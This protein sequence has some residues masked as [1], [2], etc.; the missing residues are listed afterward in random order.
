MQITSELIERLLY[1]EES[2]TLDFKQGQYPFDNASDEQKSELL[3]D[4]LAFANAFRRTDAFILIGVKD[5]KGGKSRVTG[6]A[7]QLDDAKVQQFINSKTQQPLTFVY[8]GFIHDGKPIGVIH[9]PMQKRPLYIKKNFGKVEK[10]NVD[11]RRGSSTAIAKPEEVAQMGADQ[12]ITQGIEPSFNLNL[13]G[14]KTGAVI[15]GPVNI[16]ST[17]LDVPAEQDIPDH[18][19]NNHMLARV[20]HTNRSYYRELARFTQLRVFLHPIRIA[21]TNESSVSA[22]DVRLVIEV[23]DS[24]GKHVFEAGNDMLEPGDHHRRAAR[25]PFR[26]RCSIQTLV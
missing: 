7:N 1:E 8:L 11:L 23:D 9:I 13:H 12:I 4:I 6:A 24:D 21:L 14:P 15:D 5:V 18:V 16:E 25:D 19:S 22:H 2:T 17:W 26:K 10:E 3:K 20:I